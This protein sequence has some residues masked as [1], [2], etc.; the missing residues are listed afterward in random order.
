MIY[1]FYYHKLQASNHESTTTKI[2]RTPSPL[3]IF[4]QNLI[5]EI[6]KFFFILN[7][8]KKTRIH[9]W[10]DKATIIII[11]HQDSNLEIQFNYKSIINIY[12]YCKKKKLLFALIVL[13]TILWLINKH[14]KFYY[15]W[16][17]VY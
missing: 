7:K 16:L 11:N 8:K 17:V 15:I 6:K 13:I 4:I 10:Q 9:F 14:E 12:L 2:K 3:Q 1:L 5:I